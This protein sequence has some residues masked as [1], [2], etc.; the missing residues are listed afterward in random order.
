MKNCPIC[1]NQSFILKKGITFKAP[2]HDEFFKNHPN[3]I[4]NILKCGGCSL[5]FCDPMPTEKV[6]KTLYSKTYKNPRA[7]EEIVKLNA[8]KNIKLLKKY[9][10]TKK[11]SLM[12]YGSGKENNFIKAGNVKSWYGYDPYLNWTKVKKEHDFITMWGILEHSVDPIKTLRDV[13]RLLKNKGRIA[14]TT[15]FNPFTNISY[16]HRPP[17]HTL[18]FTEE[19]IRRLFKKTGFKI[20]E[21]S[22]YEMWQKPNIYL[23]CIF[24]SSKMAQKIRNKIHI[25]IKKPI[26]VPT[27]E[28]FIV[29]EKSSK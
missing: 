24:N 1:N 20:L 10:L 9:G 2:E 3:L 16:N 29:G 17:E 12:D 21:Y 13:Y 18:Y 23:W 26:L 7:S 4:Y 22:S 8:K 25:D 28:V 6:L 27:N 5:E 14:I 11:S 19:S 15:V